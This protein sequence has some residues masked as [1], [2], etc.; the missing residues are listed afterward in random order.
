MMSFKRIGLHIFFWLVAGLFLTL[1]LGNDGGNYSYTFFFVAL[2]M[3]IAIATSYVFNYFLIP[4]FLFHGAYLKFIIYGFF[5][6]VFSIYLEMLLVVFVFIFK[7]DYTY[8]NMSRS[9]TNIIQLGMAMYFV[10]FLST[11]IYMVKRWSQPKRDNLDN[12]FIQIRVDRKTTRVDLNEIQYVESLDNYVK[13]HL[14]DKILVTKEKISALSEKLPGFFLRTHRS[15]L[16]NTNH[17][18]SFTRESLIINTSSIP[19][20][21][22]YKK[23]VIAYL[24]GTN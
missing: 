14:S 22:S 24:D 2:L 5:Y 21:R 7:A 3:P 20:S 12:Q 15:F 16:V 4:K 17:I 11:L 9:S 1:V 10:V 19:I 8:D 13:L 18:T 6:F 23:E